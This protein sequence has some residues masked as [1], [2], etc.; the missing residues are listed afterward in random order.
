MHRTVVVKRGS[1]RT[2]RSDED[3]LAFRGLC[4][5]AAQELEHVRGHPLAERSTLTLSSDALVQVF[6]KFRL[7]LMSL[8]EV[9]MYI[10]ATPFRL[11]YRID[12]FL[13]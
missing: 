1:L 7:I 9:D 10:E 3:L 4:I 12:K 11:G 2:F 5:F 8:P 6:G 13:I